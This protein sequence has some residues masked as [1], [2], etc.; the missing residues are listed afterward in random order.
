MHVLACPH[1]KFWFLLK[2]QL[3]SQVGLFQ[4]WSTFVIG[5][6]FLEYKKIVSFD[7]HCFG[8]FFMIE[9]VRSIYGRFRC[10]GRLPSSR[11]SRSWAIR[12]PSSPPGIF[13]R[14][15]LRN[16]VRWVGRVSSGL[17]IDTVTRSALDRETEVSDLSF[18]SG[19][20]RTG[21]LRELKSVHYSGTPRTDF[22]ERGNCSRRSCC[23]LERALRREAPEARQASGVFWRRPFS[24]R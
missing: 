13:L 4:V 18:Y 9:L 24:S 8:R 15:N 5:R 7:R 1:S 2:L 22:L 20:L 19:R 21:F 16:L 10:N 11:N 23:R 3:E 12:S 14:W 17:V 6:Y